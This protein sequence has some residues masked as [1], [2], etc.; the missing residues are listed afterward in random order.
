MQQ[1]I[2]FTEVKRT[3]LFYDLQNKSYIVESLGRYGIFNCFYAHKAGDDSRINLIKNRLENVATIVTDKIKQTKIPIRKTSL[4]IID[5]KI[6]SIMDDKES[7][8]ETDE[9]T[10]GTALK[11]QH[12]IIV[13]ANEF[14]DDDI[15]MPVHILIHEWAHMWSF[16][17][18]K[19]SWTIVENLHDS[20]VDNYIV[21]N[22]DE[23][24]EILKTYIVKGF[25][26]SMPQLVDL[27]IKQTNLNWPLTDMQIND[28]RKK[29]I[30]EVFASKNDKT[31]LYENLD[32]ILDARK[33]YSLVLRKLKPASKSGILHSFSNWIK[34]QMDDEPRKKAED[35]IKS[36]I[37]TN[38]I[39]IRNQYEQTFLRS[40]FKKI[41]EKDSSQKRKFVNE[42]GLIVKYPFTDS[43]EL[44]SGLITLYVLKPNLLPQT[45]TQVLHQIF[46]KT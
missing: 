33:F 24:Y 20:I 34:S 1:K 4:F 44:I 30:H 42:T 36:S 18:P 14:L 41:I 27:L 8:P 12:S 43:H 16:M 7:E 31:Y 13:P 9:I 32:T 23:V 37:D 29:I 17:M 38:F 11:Q 19:S 3:K 2:L 28:V 45:Y 40:F 26:I 22:K 21:K 25:E 10:Y 6:S 5:N 15:L 46:E 35:V 39:K